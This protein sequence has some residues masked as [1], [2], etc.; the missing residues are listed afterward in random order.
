MTLLVVGL[1]LGVGVGDEV[2]RGGYVIEK[3]IVVVAGVGGGY[4]IV[5]AIT[6]FSANPSFR[7]EA[8]LSTQHPPQ[9]KVTKSDSAPSPHPSQKA[10]I[11]AKVK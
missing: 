4:A 7:S 6:N 2:E 8:P 11:T 10:S 3:G 9:V 1:E 5:T